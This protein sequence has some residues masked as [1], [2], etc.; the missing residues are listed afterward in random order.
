[1]IMDIP[2]N[3]CSNHDGHYWNKKERFNWMIIFFF[4]MI[5]LFC[6]RVSMPICLPAISKEL[7]WNKEVSG[8]VLSS[9][10]CGYLISNM[11]GGYLA[12]KIGGEIVIYYTAFG[13]AFL[14]IF[15]P[16]LARSSILLPYSTSTVICARFLTGLFQGVFFP[17]LSAIMT[18][19][20]PVS[21]KG[22]F[23]SFTFSGNAIGIMLSGLFGSIILEKFDWSL[24]F[25]IIGSIS[26]L[27]IFWLRYQIVNRS[28]DNLIKL[29]Y[30]QKEPIPWNRLGTSGAFW[31]LFIAYFTRSG[32][33]HNLMSWTPV[34][35]HDNFPGSK[36]WLFNTLPWV[37]NFIFAIIFGYLANR[38]IANGYS[39]TF[40][41]KLYASVN[42]IGLSFCSIL[43]NF[44][45]TFSYSVFIMSLNIG[46]NA[47]GSSSIMVNSQDIAPRHSGA[48]H[49][50]INACGAISGVMYVYL[51]G[52][53]LNIT[54]DWSLIFIITSC[55]G[56]IGFLSFL[57]FGSGKHVV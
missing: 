53:I 57:L 37:L 12:D 35:F 30:C 55:S 39:V 18:K 48:V 4:G 41:R 42:L 46:V 20:V 32:C 31:G 23:S 3:I 8:M 13:W 17:S 45:S 22:F 10:Y 15:L 34:Y 14:S 54:G 28:S 44:T 9:F 21:A 2:L 36:E 6:V 38:L 19:H 25:I 24:L 16:F 26:I 56:F 40:V 47:F 52:Y 29:D 5:L 1:M 51:T 33:F 50:F 49:G 7:S 11:I 27:W 43:L